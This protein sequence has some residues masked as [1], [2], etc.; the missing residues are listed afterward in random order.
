[1]VVSRVRFCEFTIKTTAE[2]IEI[3]EIYDRG[4]WW[5]RL[6][7]TKG[8][9]PGLM[10]SKLKT[11]EDERCRQITFR[12]FWGS[13]SE[14]CIIE[15]TRF[16]FSLLTFSTGVFSALRQHG[17][18]KLERWRASWQ[19]SSLKSCSDENEKVVKFVFLQFKVSQQT[20]PKR[21][22]FNFTQLNSSLLHGVH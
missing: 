10:N 6:A 21:T 22:K 7:M 2:G 11:G 4:G 8:L 16:F 17:C 1:M 5:N 18:F 12:Q 15:S 9:K 3:G 20:A 14:R 13:R 19:V